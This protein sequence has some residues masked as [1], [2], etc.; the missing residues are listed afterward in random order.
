MRLQ[1]HR[2]ILQKRRARAC[3]AKGQTFPVR[4]SGRSAGQ[5]PVRQ[6]KPNEKRHFVTLVH[7]SNGPLRSRAD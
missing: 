7:Q 1:G 5:R 3:E 6:K 2:D 4:G